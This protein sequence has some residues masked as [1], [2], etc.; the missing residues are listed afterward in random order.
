[1]FWIQEKSFSIFATY[2][3]KLPDYWITSIA[4]VRLLTG[5]F[6]IRHHIHGI[7]FVQDAASQM[8]IKDHETTAVLN[9]LS[10][11]LTINR[12]LVVVDDLA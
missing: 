2:Q 3:V 5:H 6:K 7:N 1:M 10:K 11:R 9:T 4:K 12:S 8:F